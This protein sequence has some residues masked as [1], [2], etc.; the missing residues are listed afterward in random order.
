MPEESDIKSFDY[1]SFARDLS[2]QASEFIPQD[3]KN[4]DKK[5]INVFSAT[6]KR[7]GFPVGV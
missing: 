4:D 2:G 1:E 7:Y 5:F 6:L 3:I